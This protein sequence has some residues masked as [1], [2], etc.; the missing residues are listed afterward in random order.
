MTRHRV[1]T[2]LLGLLILPVG[3]RGQTQNQSILLDLPLASQRATVSQ[4][5]GL[6]T[7][8]IT[9]HRPLAKGRKILGE[10]VPYG[11]VWRAG[12][13]ENTTISFSDP[14][15]VEGQTLPAG[16]YGLHMLPEPERWTVIFSK[17]WTSWGS[18]SYD[19]KEDALRVVVQPA[20]K[21]HREALLYEIDLLG[22]DTALV[23]LE[24]EKIAVPF[25][26]S[27]NVPEITLASVRRQLRSLPG[28][29]WR[30][31]NDA[32]IYCLENKTNLEEA[33]RWV[34]QSIQG[35]ER[36][37]NLQTRSQLLAATGKTSEAQSVMTRAISSANASQL[38]NYGRQL[39]AEKKTQEAVKIFRMNAQKNPGTWFVHAGLA[40]GQSAAGDFK[41]AAKSMK[42]ALSR[43]PDSQKTYIQGL[44]E[45]LEKERDI[46]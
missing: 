45:R 1:L 37:E 39:L 17:N 12:A 29:T 3:L 9:Y 38:H 7:I 10:V 28:F 44:V 22:P 20:A 25:K 24:W 41:A 36:F 31:L 33:L 40:R 6:T 32:A 34:D 13:N 5:V 8:A 11:Q 35:E 15:R 16:T 4:R 2:F 21:D 42:E 14:V 19:Q 43:A 46:N 30:G 23:S 26:V 18:F 27:A